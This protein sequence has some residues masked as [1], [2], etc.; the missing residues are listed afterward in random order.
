[1]RSGAMSQDA[2]PPAGTNPAAAPPSMADVLALPDGERELVLWLLRKGEASWP[3]LLAASKLEEAP[4]RALLELLG[5]RGFIQV[6]GDV[7]EPHYRTRLA[8]RRSRPALGD[9]LKRLTE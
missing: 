6:S 3:E 5:A 1:M 2:K 8:G 4:C 7:Q 9:A